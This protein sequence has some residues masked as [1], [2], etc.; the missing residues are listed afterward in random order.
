MNYLD[1]LSSNVFTFVIS[2][3]SMIVGLFVSPFLDLAKI[4]YVAQGA[5]SD[6][7]NRLKK[8]LDSQLDELL[9]VFKSNHMIAANMS[10]NGAVVNDFADAIIQYE[11]IRDLISQVSINREFKEKGIYDRI[12]TTISTIEQTNYHGWPESSDKLRL[13][14]QLNHEIYVRSHN[15]NPFHAREVLVIA[16]AFQ[17]ADAPSKNVITR[18]YSWFRRK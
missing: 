16:S 18:I 6:E 15:P 3:T 1:S 14:K 4:K 12:L 2:I 5:A 8:L 13:L 9:L 17:K 10:K 7:S 11:N